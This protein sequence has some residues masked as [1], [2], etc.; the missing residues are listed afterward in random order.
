MSVVVITFFTSVAAR[1]TLVAPFTSQLDLFNGRILCGTVGNS[2]CSVL[3]T[4]WMVKMTITTR[5]NVR[6]E[7]KQLPTIIIRNNLRS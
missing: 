5:K 6:Y 3:K 1:N 2:L 7:V 4:T